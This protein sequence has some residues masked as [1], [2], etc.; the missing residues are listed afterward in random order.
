MRRNKK[1]KWSVGAST[2][3]YIF[4]DHNWLVNSMPRFP[5]YQ[6]ILDIG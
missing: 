2:V 1:K 3:E 4:V 6:M 5:V